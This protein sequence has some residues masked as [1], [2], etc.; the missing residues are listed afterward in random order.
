MGLSP[1]LGASGELGEADYGDIQILRHELQAS[2]Y[3]RNL[4]H[5]VFD[6]CAGADKSE[7]IYDYTVDILEPACARFHFGNGYRARVIEIELAV[8]ERRGGKA[9]A[10][11][12]DPI[13]GFS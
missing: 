10:R 9:E 12:I 3:L 8:V 5:A 13:L 11:P 7:V 4:L 6:L 1:A 2:G